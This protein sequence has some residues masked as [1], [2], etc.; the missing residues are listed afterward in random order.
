M[1]LGQNIKSS[2]AN[3]SYKSYSYK[4]KSR[5]LKKD[6]PSLLVVLTTKRG[7]SIRALA[8][9]NQRKR[10]TLKFQRNKSSRDK[11]Q[12]QLWSDRFNSG[13]YLGFK[14]QSVTRL[15]LTF[16]WQIILKSMLIFMPFSSTDYRRW[17]EAKWICTNCTESNGFHRKH[18]AGWRWGY[19]PTRMW[20]KEARQIEYFWRNGRNSCESPHLR[21]K[22]N[23]FYKTRFWWDFCRITNAGT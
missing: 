10:K 8:K 16:K 23:V 9:H 18:L 3:W 21:G 1:I 17:S 12:L 13:E 5:I 11:S 20:I 7:G 2:T 22:T 15:E 6:Y 19:N 14:N 4:Y